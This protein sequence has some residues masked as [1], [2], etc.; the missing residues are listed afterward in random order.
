MSETDLLRSYATRKA[1]CAGGFTAMRE[2]LV[3]SADQLRI[4]G[5]PGVKTLPNPATLGKLPSRCRPMSQRVSS[6]PS[7]SPPIARLN[8]ERSLEHGFPNQVRLHYVSLDGCH[9]CHFAAW[10]TPTIPPR[11]CQPRFWKAASALPLWLHNSPVCSL[12]Y[13]RD[14]SSVATLCW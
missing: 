2:C 4:F 7:N 6:H 12:G 8:G 11:I 14:S 1:R 3:V 9:A 5:C 13:V 10:K